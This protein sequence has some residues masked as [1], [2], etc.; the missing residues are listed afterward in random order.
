MSCGKLE[1]SNYYVPI[2]DAPGH[3]DCIKS[4]ITG[5]F[6]ADCAVLIVAAGV[7][8]L[9]AGISLQEWANLWACPLAYTPLGVKQPVVDI[10]KMDSTESLYSQKRYEEIVKEEPAI[11]KL[12]ATLT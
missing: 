6:Q 2:T 9:E 1:A 5:T 8:I 3:R 4:V 7:G 12:A 11:W 10:N